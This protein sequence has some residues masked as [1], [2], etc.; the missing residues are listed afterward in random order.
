VSCRRECG[1][2]CECLSPH[3]DGKTCADCYN[4]DRCVALFGT[5][6]SDTYC[7]WIPSRAHYRLPMPEIHSDDPPGGR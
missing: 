6:P 1:D 7:Q 4:V 2:C 5:K 3:R